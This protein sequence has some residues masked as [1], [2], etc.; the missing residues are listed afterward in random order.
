M[1]QNIKS[2]R[3]EPLTHLQFHTPKTD[4]HSAVLQ[5]APHRKGP[6]PTRALC[7][8]LRSRRHFDGS[9]KDR[10]DGASEP[11]GASEH[12]VGR[13]ENVGAKHPTF[14][15]GFGGMEGPFGPHK[16]TISESGGE[17]LFMDFP[18]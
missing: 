15:G 14:S 5:Q 9:S 4:T 16:L 18:D 8:E 10:G 17:V 11:P 3:E 7:P 1:S 13:R 6:R 2:A 12:R